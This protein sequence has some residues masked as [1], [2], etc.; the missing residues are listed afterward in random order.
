MP[1]AVYIRDC[2]VKPYKKFYKDAVVDAF[3]EWEKA[4]ENRVKFNFINDPAKAD[5][6]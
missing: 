6:R 3:R 4:S 5:I 2:E 1:I